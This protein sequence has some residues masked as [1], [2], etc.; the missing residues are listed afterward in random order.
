[1]AKRIKVLHLID[2]LGRGGTER[3]LITN[4]RVIDRDSFDHQVLVLF[5]RSDNLLKEL[6]G[7]SLPV[8]R[9]SLK[10]KHNFFYAIWKIMHVIR[11]TGA[12]L[13]HTHNWYADIYGRLAGQLSGKAVISSIH[14]TH[15][16]PQVLIDTLRHNKLKLFFTKYLDM[17]TGKLCVDKFIAVSGWVRKSAVKHLRLKENSID[18]IYNSID[19]NYFSPVSEER[20]LQKKKE[21]GIKEGE[22][23]L[24]TVGRAVPMKGQ[25]HMIAAMEKIVKKRKDIRLFIRGTGWMQNMLEVYRDRLGL[26]QYIGFL[27][28]Q[29]DL[30]VFLQT[31]D[32]FLFTSLH[33]GLG[34]AQLEAMAMMKP[35]IAFAVGPM[36]EVVKDG[37]SG[38]LVEPWDADKLADAILALIDDPERMKAMGKEGRKIAAEKFNIENNVKQLEAFYRNTLA[39]V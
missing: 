39:Y 5:E 9:L 4:L 11:K 19:L 20:I 34:I 33:E 32:I 12:D 6:E 35:I 29:Q 37:V 18:T 10:S 14:D 21:L 26:K 13:L 15:Y 38:I 17:L 16:E 36:P 25:K 31:G 28:P 3:L 23:A 30:R 1:M 7:L 27:G 2:A 22:K 24:I 8:Y